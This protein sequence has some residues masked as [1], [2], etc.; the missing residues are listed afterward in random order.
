MKTPWSGRERKVKLKVAGPLV[1]A[2]YRMLFADKWLIAFLLAGSIAASAGAAVV[3]GPAMVWGGVTPAF[4]LTSGSVVG[5]LVSAAA[6]GVFTFITQLTTGA[7]VAAAVLRAEGTTPTLRRSLA[8]AW[9]RRRQILAWALVSTVIGVLVRMLERVGVGGVIAGLT[10]NI[11]WAA[12]TV[13]AM[14]VVIV[15]G[16]MPVETV[17]RSAR[18]LRVS[19]GATVVSGLSVA[20]PWM[21]ASFACVAVGVA[22]AVTFLAGQV[23]LAGAL[24]VIGVLGFVFCVT[25]ST[26]ATTY[27][28]TYL[29]RY[30]NGAEVPGVS[31][32]LL[33]PLAS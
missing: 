11:G 26:A 28:Q 14:P 31:P 33:P 6:L 25:V 9:S 4:S 21:V 27:L 17:R 19:F 12:A 18:V 24:I 13:F 1:D 16:T 20:L 29:Y 10:V 7:V 32:S 8:I 3:A 22:G 15:E 5:V 23:V 30:A 2:S